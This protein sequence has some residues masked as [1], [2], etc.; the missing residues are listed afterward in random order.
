MTDG[1]ALNRDG[2]ESV[3]ESPFQI[4]TAA[5]TRASLLRGK[6]TLCTLL[7]Y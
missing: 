6:E 2:P 4:V 3:S 1:R 5:H 7:R